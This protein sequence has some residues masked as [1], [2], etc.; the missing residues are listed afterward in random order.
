MIFDEKIHIAF[1]YKNF[2]ANP[3]VSHI[4]LGVSG[5][6]NVKILQK[7]GIKASLWPVKFPHEI[8]DHINRANLNTPVT[9]VVI[10]APWIP[11]QTLFQLTQSN[12]DILFAVNCHSNVGFLQADTNGVKLVREYIEL[13]KGTFNFR[14]AGNS[15]KFCL[16]LRQ[17]YQ[18]SCEYLP[19]MYYL[20]DSVDC[21]KP[22]WNGGVLRIG[23]FGAT[24]PQKN[25]ASM[26]GAA[27]AISKELKADVEFYVSG[28]RT[29]GGGNTILNAVRAMLVNEPGIKLVELNWATWP[30]FRS[31]V[32]TMHL[33]LQVSYT[34]SFNMVTAD[35]VAEGVPSVV[36]D[37]IDWAPKYWQAYADDVSD[38]ARVGR[39]LIFDRSAAKDGLRSLEQHNRDS[40]E[41]WE[42]YLGIEKSKYIPSSQNNST[43]SG[44]II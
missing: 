5:L 37:A 20:D 38:I 3:G 25:I 4:G 34:E 21:N 1:V 40:F 28:G 29:E 16:W 12:T 36:S 44:L 32:R 10:A 6:N 43:S 13:Q 33:L 41:I 24:R 8:Q 14:M 7:Q 18:T 22:L 26:A 9:H 19:N 11:T 42:E 35:G 31:L 30:Q 15:K 27:L 39:Q 2:A 23:A 17:A